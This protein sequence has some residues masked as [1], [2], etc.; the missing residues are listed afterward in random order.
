MNKQHELDGYKITVRFKDGG[1]YPGKYKVISI[2]WEERE[3]TVSRMH[4]LVTTVAN[5]S[6]SMFMKALRIPAAFDDVEIVPEF[7][8]IETVE[9]AISAALDEGFTSMNAAKMM[10][11]RLKNLEDAPSR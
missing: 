8:A 2:D 9:Q 10:A 5:G 4:H 3:L 1:K 11:Q 7:P 6:L